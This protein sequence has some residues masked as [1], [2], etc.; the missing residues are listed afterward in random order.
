MT[1]SPRYRI[2]SAL[3]T[4]L[5]GVG[6]AAEPMRQEFVEQL[7][8]SER[9]GIGVDSMSAE[10]VALLEAAVQRFAAER[11]EAAA[12]K[13]RNTV[14]DAMAEEVSRRD[15][16][17]TDVRQELEKTKGALRASDSVGKESLLDRAKVLLR[18]GTKVEYAEIQS[19]LTEPFRG[20]RK[21]MLFRLENGQIWQVTEGT[22]VDRA[23]PAGKSVTVVPG[24]LGSFFLEFEDVRP[25]AKV[26]LVSH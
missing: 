24:V 15:T 19:R 16:L 9:M 11:S 4:S 14:S 7:T 2:V 18:P 10:Q 5:L 21:G 1:R 8:Q 12:V 3:L 17:L 6:L 20:W 22:Y 26:T 25:R 13:A 23:Q